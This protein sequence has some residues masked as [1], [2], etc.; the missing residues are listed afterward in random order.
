MARILFAVIVASFCIGGCAQTMKIKANPTA[1]QRILYENGKEVL[2]SQKKS[3]LAVAALSGVIKSNQRPKFIITYFNGTSFPIN[4]STENI[5]AIIN[6]LQVKIFTFDELVEEIERNRRSQALTAALVGASQTMNAS[7]GKQYHSG[8]YN[9]NYY[10]SGGSGYGYGTY[11][12]TTYDPAASAQ[13]QAVIQ[14]QTM[15]NINNANAAASNSLSEIERTILRKQ[16]VMPQNWHG[17]YVVLQK[18]PL[19]ELNNKLNILISIDDETHM[20]EYNIVESGR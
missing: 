13:A 3:M 6:G 16:T 9:T 15:S 1:S 17:G 19:H 4:F 8:S 5:S 11:S 18:L 20:F 2:V 12:G 14:A 10:G 7:S